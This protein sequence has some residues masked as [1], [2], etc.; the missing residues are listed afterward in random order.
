MT[1]LLFLFCL[2]L[3]SGTLKS[4]DAIRVYGGINLTNVKY[5]R[6]DPLNQADTSFWRINNYVLPILGADIDFN[7]NSKFS[8]TTGLG[9][10]FMGSRNYNFATPPEGV[11]IDSNLRIGYLRIPAILSYKIAHGISIFAGYSLNYSFRK[12]INFIAINL[13]TL[14]SKGIYKNFHHALLF[15]IK[16]EWKNWSITANYHAGISRVWDTKDFYPDKRAYLTL[17]G[18]QFTLGYIIRK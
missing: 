8:L 13:E 9:V 4:Q 14:E 11:K 12:N 6:K 7:I 5:Y 18:F 17:N 3:V 16:E 1:K 15:G 10:S 2:F